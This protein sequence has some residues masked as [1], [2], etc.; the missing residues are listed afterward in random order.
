MIF[1]EMDMMPDA[2]LSLKVVIDPES[3]SGEEDI[4]GLTI[5]SDIDIAMKTIDKLQSL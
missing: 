1:I 4:L 3:S 2:S 5:A